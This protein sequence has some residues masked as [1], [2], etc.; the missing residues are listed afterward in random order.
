MAKQGSKK[1]NGTL[2]IYSWIGH[3]ITR[4]LF[5]KALCVL[6]LIA[7]AAAV[8]RFIQMCAAVAGAGHI[9]VN[10]VFVASSWFSLFIPQL[11]YVIIEQTKNKNKKELTN[12]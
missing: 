12:I 8:P 5:S 10:F 1:Q 4:L 3:N 2:A 7:G 9:V 11:Y 6:V